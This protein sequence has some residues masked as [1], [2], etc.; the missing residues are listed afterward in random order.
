M[1]PADHMAL[2]DVLLSVVTLV[3]QEVMLLHGMVRVT[4]PD[5]PGNSF[6]NIFPLWAATV[7]VLGYLV[8]RRRDGVVRQLAMRLHAATCVVTAF[9]LAWDALS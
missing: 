5:V 2:V 6:R 1:T 8:A 3:I 9:S 4:Q 7:P